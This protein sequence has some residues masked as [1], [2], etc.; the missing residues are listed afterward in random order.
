MGPGRVE[1]H[2][3]QHEQHEDQALVDVGDGF[4]D[5]LRAE[6]QVAAGLYEAE[7]PLV[8]GVGDPEHLRL[9][10]QPVGLGDSPRVAHLGTGQF[11]TAPGAEHPHR[12]HQREQPDRDHEDPSRRRRAERDREAHQDQEDQRGADEARRLQ[13]AAGRLAGLVGHDLLQRALA[14]TRLHVPGGVAEGPEDA[15]AQALLDAGS[16]LRRQHR[17]R[18]L[19]HQP[20]QRQPERDPQQCRDRGADVQDSGAGGPALAVDDL[21]GDLGHERE[22]QAFAEARQ[23]REARERGD[24]PALVADQQLELGH[25]RAA[26]GAAPAGAEVHRLHRSPPPTAPRA[27]PLRRARPI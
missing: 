7:H 22:E 3:P 19:Q 27:P 18:P 13:R 1:R 8:L 11:A 15:L 2:Q 26:S 12:A 4:G 24:V 14:V 23:Q 10:G 21:V 9:L 6:E 25:Q 20:E 16:D 17:D 5:H